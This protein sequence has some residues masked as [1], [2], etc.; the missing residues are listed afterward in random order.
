MQALPHEPQ[1]AMSV[2]GS[3]HAVVEPDAHCISPEAHATSGGGVSATGMSST[4]GETVVES[5]CVG[6]SMASGNWVDSSQPATP[7]ATQAEVSSARNVG[8]FIRVTPGVEDARQIDP[9]GR[10]ERA[11]MVAGS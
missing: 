9:P 7:K 11:S 1:F 8:R 6:T 3:T 4:G 5:C 10:G 2:M